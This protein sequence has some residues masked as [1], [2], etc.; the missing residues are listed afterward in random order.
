[1]MRLLILIVYQLHHLDQYQNINYDQMV[2]LVVVDVDQ[3]HADL[4]LVHHLHLIYLI[5]SYYYH[6]RLFYHHHRVLNVLYHPVD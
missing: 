1:M 4:K 3:F 2:Y 5:K 6:Q